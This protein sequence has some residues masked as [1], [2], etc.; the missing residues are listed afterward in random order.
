MSDA[1]FDREKTEAYLRLAD[2]AWTRFQSRRD[3]EWKTAIGLWSVFGAGAGVVL[4]A[5]TW[6]PGLG[7][8]I[9]AVAVVVAVGIYYCFWWIPYLTREMQRDQR[10]SYYWE[11]HVHRSLGVPLPEHLMPPQPPPGQQ[12]DW[13]SAQDQNIN[14]VGGVGSTARKL[15]RRTHVV[16]KAQA[17]ITLV[18]GVLFVGAMW[19]KYYRNSPPSVPP[20]A[21]TVSSLPSESRVVIEGNGL[22]LESVRLGGAGGI[23]SLPSPQPPD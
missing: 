16:Q 8:V 14:V 23:T 5:R 11:T 12:G 19:T 13:P 7:E 18:F 21:P 3:V 17:A 6:S 22:E 10:V 9:A 1:S 15:S 20:A 4:T 2:R